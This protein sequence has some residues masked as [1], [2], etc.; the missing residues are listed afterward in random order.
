MKGK[1][2]KLARALLISPKISN[3]ALGMNIIKGIRI[4]TII[5][6]LALCS[7]QSREDKAAALLKSAEYEYMHGRYKSALAAIDSM[8]TMY[9]DAVEVRRK[10]IP[11][12]RE[13]QLKKAQEAAD[14]LEAAYQTA[15]AECTAIEDS[16]HAAGAKASQELVDEVTR[17]RMARDSVRIARD[18]EVAKVR[19]IHSKMEGNGGDNVNAGDTDEGNDD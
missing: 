17:R 14:S 10:A 19:L 3:F 8:R 18:T 13:I 16:F 2:K 4:T 6:A 15:E 11:L 7:C 9:P 1:S 12:Q 5:L